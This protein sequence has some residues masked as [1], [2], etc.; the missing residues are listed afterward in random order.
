MPLL[1]APHQ[2]PVLSSY[3]NGSSGTASFPARAFSR[4]AWASPSAVRQWRGCTL[5]S[6]TFDGV[7]E[8]SNRIASARL[9]F[10]LQAT[11]E[12]LRRGGN[13]LCSF[14]ERP[15]LVNALQTLFGTSALRLN[16]QSLPAGGLSSGKLALCLIGAGQ[17]NK[18]G[19]GMGS[20][21]RICWF[22][23]TAWA[24]WR[25]GERGPTMAIRISAH[26]SRCATPQPWRCTYTPSTSLAWWSVRLA[27]PAALASLRRARFG[28]FQPAHA[29][30]FT[31]S[32]FWQLR[33]SAERSCAHCCFPRFLRFGRCRASETPP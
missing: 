21:E 24:G 8:K 23:V 1:P 13:R 19:S 9:L 17:E 16:P 20:R 3:P 11:P 27:M 32:C 25:S 28:F 33:M 29:L 2:A 30:L 7:P 6:L 31:H 12:R 10:S 26:I 15:L 22:S 5:F 14:G 18:D 4:A